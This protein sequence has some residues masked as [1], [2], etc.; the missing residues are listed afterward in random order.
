MSVTNEQFRSAM[1]HLAGHV[2]L[3]TTADK[4]GVRSG[5]TATAVCS[6]S[7]DPPTILCC[8]NQN[9]TTYKSIKENGC[10]AINVLCH[11]DEELANRFAGPI[12]GDDRF[13]VGEWTV[14]VTGSPLL[15]S[16]LASFDCQ[17]NDIV[18]GSS[19]GI[20][21]GLI[22]SVIARTEEE[23]PLLYAHGKYASLIGD[24]AS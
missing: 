21:M 12:K 18:D 8:V 16:A 24:K 13:A 2:C 11:Y 22:Q 10:F 23:S 5:L 19:H 17:L 15:L 20:F 3:I 7:A 14:G 6:V 1:R 4:S 9:N